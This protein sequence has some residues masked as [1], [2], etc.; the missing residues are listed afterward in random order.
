[1]KNPYQDQLDKDREESE[2]TNADIA[3]LVSLVALLSVL[4]WNLCRT[5]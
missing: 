1:M 4:M 3:A 5:M 2:Y